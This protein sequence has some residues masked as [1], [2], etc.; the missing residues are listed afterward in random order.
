M[1]EFS[2]NLHLAHPRFGLRREAQRHAAFVRTK[3]YQTFRSLTPA[4]KRCRGS[5]LPP[6]SKCFATFGS[7]GQRVSVL[8][9][10]SPLTLFRL[11]SALHNP[12]LIGTKSSA[13]CLLISMTTPQQFLESFLQEKTA[14]WAE[15]RPHLTAVYSKYFGE[16]LLQHANYFMPMPRDTVHAVVEDVRQSDGVASA[17]TSERFKT[18]ALRTRYRLAASDESWRIIGIDRECFW[19]HGTGQSNGSSCQQCNGEGWHQPARDAA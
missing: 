6:H 11:H 10:A 14:A 7:R 2:K 12:P 8:D 16:P 5:A 4:R 3:I 18:A 15:A 9:C 19:C 13:Q 17:V 1:M